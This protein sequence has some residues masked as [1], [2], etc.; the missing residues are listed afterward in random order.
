MILYILFVIIV[1]IQVLF[2]GYLFSKFSFANKPKSTFQDIPASIIIACKNEAINLEKNLPFIINQTFSVFEIIL[3]DDASTDATASIIKKFAG[4]YPFV[5]A[6]TIPKN[7]SYRG[8]KKKALSLGISQASYEHLVFT[9][10][11]C[12]PH[13]KYWLRDMVSGFN[14]RT[15]IVV[16]Y[17]P[18]QKKN[19]FLNQLIRYETLLTAWQYFSYALSGIPYMGVGRNLAYTKSLFQQAQG[20][21]SHQQV[22]SGDDD[23]FI[24]QI[25]TRDNV[26]LCWSQ[27][28]FMYSPPE[29]NFSDWIAQKR[30]HITTATHYRSIHK[31]LLV[32]FYVSQFLFYALFM[33]L[34]WQG[35]RIKQV[36]FLLGIRYFFYYLNLIPVAY[37]LDEKDIILPAPF[38]ELYLIVIQLRIFMANLWQQPKKW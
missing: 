16:G 34:L 10:A 22:L 20:F 2:Y 23:L 1:L 17:G 11:D 28:S 7:T 30:R 36:F 35:F 38:L 9:D 24:S 33:V 13:S 25:A 18:Y 5:K 31:L 19:G 15:K 8:N 37:K 21:T 27:E 4:Q 3:I 26:A 32:L 14:N 12:K 6:L 29:A